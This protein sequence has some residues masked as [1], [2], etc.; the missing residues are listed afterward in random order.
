MTTCLTWLAAASFAA[1]LGALGCGGTNAG[2]GSGGDGGPADGAGA[3]DGTSTADTG[4]DASGG[5]D[6]TSGGDVATT[7]TGSPEAGDDAGCTGTGMTCRTCCRTDYAAG[8]KKLVAAELACACKPSICGPLD[9]GAV[10]GG[11]DA[12]D[13]GIGACAGTCGGTTLPAT[14]CDKCLTD[15]T[16]SMAD[17]GECYTSVSMACEKDTDCV[18][19]VTCATGCE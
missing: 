6:A 17:P 11:S 12:S 2:V 13:L 3:M 14:A 10:D 19:Y 8:Y 18:A 7:E 1:C 9:A 5:N 16:G 15:A 4:G